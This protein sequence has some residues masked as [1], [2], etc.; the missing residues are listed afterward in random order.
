MMSAWT[1]ENVPAAIQGIALGNAGLASLIVLLGGIYNRS[2]EAI[3][4]VYILAPISIFFLSLYLGKALFH[5]HAFLADAVSPTTNFTY[6][7][8]AICLSFLS[9][10][11]TLPQ[12][13]L[14]PIIGIVGVCFAA[15]L[16]L[17]QEMWFLR[18]CCTSGIVWPQPFWNP[19]CVSVSITT[20]TGASS[21]VNLPELILQ[22]AWFTGVATMVLIMPPQLYSVFRHHRILGGSGD[23]KDIPKLNDN[24]SV[25]IMQATASILCSG[26][27]AANFEPDVVGTVFFA[28]S[29]AVFILTLVALGVRRKVMYGAVKAQNPALSSMT[30]PFVITAT[31]AAFY[32]RR[33]RGGGGAGLVVLE[34]LVWILFGLAG[35]LVGSVTLLYFKLIF[36]GEMIR[37]NV[38]SEEEESSRGG[39]K[40]VSEAWEE[41]M[42]GFELE[43][44]RSD[45]GSDHAC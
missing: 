34:V 39:E 19:M 29:M 7:V 1:L 28:A 6:G 24:P 5:P 12:F 26:W 14:P 31:A 27:H 35:A 41:D 20:I 9:S 10:L 11:L 2:E 30:F 3:F 43:Q 36:F 33:H 32:Y 21:G 37:K 38:E 45:S 17:V 22:L 16:Q 15:V 23:A 25:A 13:G 18:T 44:Q 42:V 4:A 8:T 40:H